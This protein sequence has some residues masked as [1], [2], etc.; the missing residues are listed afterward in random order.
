MARTRFSI[1]FD[2]GY[3]N[4]KQQQN[5]SSSYIQGYEEG[6]LKK[7]EEDAVLGLVAIMFNKLN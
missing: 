4:R 2:D 3:K 1:G 7:L 6:S 5:S